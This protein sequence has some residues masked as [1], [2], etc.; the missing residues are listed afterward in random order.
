MVGSGVLLIGCGAM[1]GALLKGWLSRPD[2][3]GPFYVVTPRRTSVAPFLDDPRVHYVEDLSTHT[4]IADVVVCAVK[5]SMVASVLP[6]YQKL[7][8]THTLFISVAAGLP[9]SFYTSFVPRD[10]A[11]VRVMP[12]LASAVGKGI[13]LMCASRPLN[14]QEAERLTQLLEATGLVVPLADDAALEA[15][16]PLTGCGPAFLF[17]FMEALTCATKTLGVD[18]ETATRLTRALMTGC[19]VFLEQTDKD[20]ARLRE[21]VTSPKGMTWA[22]LEVMNAGDRLDIL[23]E[24]T[25]N[26]SL[27][28]AQEMRQSSGS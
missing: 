18:E 16:T 11:T 9:L 14:P 27:R 20:V 25:L 1:G 4:T 3:S 28:R 13:S 5:P 21:E 10:T 7:M 17:R 23:V 12:N 22:G 26:A 19:G 15:L 24:E 2:L 8:G 6:A